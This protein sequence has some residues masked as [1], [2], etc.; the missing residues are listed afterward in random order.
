[1]LI[2]KVVKDK[3]SIMYQSKSH[4]SV[5]LRTCYWYPVDKVASYISN[6]LVSVNR[7][8]EFTSKV[9]PLITSGFLT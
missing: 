6:L 9:A 3:F 1:M 2:S 5:N 8:Y 7:S 4:I